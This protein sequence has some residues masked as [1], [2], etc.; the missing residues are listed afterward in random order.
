MLLLVA[1]L[2][3][4]AGKK[5][6]FGTESGAL[7]DP[8]QGMQSRDSSPVQEQPTD[9]PTMEGNGLPEASL[10]TADTAATAGTGLCDADAGCICNEQVQ[11]CDPL[12]LC[13]GGL[14]CAVASNCT[15]CLIDGECVAAASPN[16]SNFCQVCAPDQNANGWTNADGAPCDDGTFCTVDDTCQAGRCDGNE[17]ECDDNVAC[18][19]VGTC[20]EEADACAAGQSQCGPNSACDVA[21]GV[22]VNTCPGCI[23]LG[24]CHPAGAEEPGNPCRV[25]DPAR[26]SSDFVAAEGKSCGAPPA[27]CS[28]QDTCNAQGQCQ[29]NHFTN[30]TSCGNPAETPCDG[31]DTCD[32][33]GN[34]LPRTVGNS[35]PCDDGNFCTVGDACQ[36]GVCSPI[37]NRNC[38]DGLACNENADQCQCQGCIVAG[39]CFAP[40]ALNGNNPC[41]VCDPARSTVSFSGNTGARCGS[42]ETE[43][44]AQD[45]CNAQG[46]CAPN[47]LPFPTP[48]SSV[49]G[50]QCQGDGRCAAPE[51]AQARLTVIVNGAGTVT[52]PSGINCG[53]GCSVLVNVGA[54][55]TLQA[56]TTNGSNSFFSN[57]SAS[58]CSGPARSCTM[59]I[60]SDRTV[61]ATFSPITNNLIFFSSE[62][63]PTDLGGVAPYDAACNRLATAAGINSNGDDAYVAVLSDSTSNIQDRLGA[64]AQ[65]WVRLDGKPFSTTQS[66]LFQNNVV[67]YP[68]I[69]DE[70]GNLVPGAGLNEERAMTGTTANG[71]TDLH[72]DDWSTTTTGTAMFGLQVGGPGL[73][74]ARNRATCS[75]E[76][77]LFCIGRTRSTALQVP[78]STGKRIWV[79]NTDFEVGGPLSPDAKCATERPSGV[80]SGVALLA[81]T[82]RPASAVLTAGANYVRID[83]QLVGTGQQISDRVILTGIWQNADGT[84]RAPVRSIGGV[85]A[86]SRAV[87][88]PGTV[89]GTCN[90]WTAAMSSTIERIGS[91]GTVNRNWWD[92][93]AIGTCGATGL[94]Y[95]VEP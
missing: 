33:R 48:C 1:L 51:P 95:C 56:N 34:C 60:D 11:S 16:P 71:T 54:Q 8:A 90:N 5:R 35:T 26:S 58:E 19:G 17:R 18:N 23:I 30:G 39:N 21:T 15:G 89:E 68:V 78:V 86:G 74:V 81:R 46:Q 7:D 75:A 27:L 55:V 92:R 14:E 31:P 69:Y 13:D 76:Y 84:Y 62:V 80:A 44:S 41:Q 29:S 50:G 10:D 85:H 82:D 70:F 20:N 73:W 53:A 87:N 65:G 59:A 77:H 67:F 3:S 72:C 88:V 43:C 83:G 38:G 45:T 79:T 36:G 49:P 40:G 57:W 61:T 64:S 4:C 28:G 22:C 32:G 94:L 47:D 66:Q 52:S 25:C 91:V 24:T 2:A 93:D 63:F 37:G 12:P 9:T 42:G 6:D